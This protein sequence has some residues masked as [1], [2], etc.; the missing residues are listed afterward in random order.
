M[1]KRSPFP[2]GS[3]CKPCWEL[4]YCPYGPLVDL[5]PHAHPAAPPVHLDGDVGYKEVVTQIQG[6]T[7]ITPEEVHDY[8]RLL[9][10]LDPDN[11]EFVKEHYFEVGCRATGH[12]CPV[13]FVQSGAT[14]TKAGRVEVRTIPRQVMLKVVR[15]DNHV[16]QSCYAYVP[17]DQVEFDHIIPFSKGGPTSV[18]NIRLL[19]RTCNRKKSNSLGELLA[20]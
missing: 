4:K 5:F 12:A 9:S 6:L 11:R 10:L 8:S 14:E 7:A 1:T 18:E 19:C 15:R 17:D 13:F 3:V 16:C 2:K 20:E